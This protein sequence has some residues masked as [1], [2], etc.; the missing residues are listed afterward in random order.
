MLSD[1]RGSH[2]FT[3][4]NLRAEVAEFAILDTLLPG[5]ISCSAIMSVCLAPTC[6]FCGMAAYLGFCCPGCRAAGSHS[7]MVTHVIARSGTEGVLL[8]DLVEDFPKDPPEDLPEDLADDDTLAP[9]R[10]KTTHRGCRRRGRGRK[11]RRAADEA[12]EIADG[13]AAAVGLARDA[14]TTLQQTLAREDGEAAPAG[15]LRLQ[16]RPKAAPGRTWHVDPIRWSGPL[17]D[18]LIEV[19]L[20]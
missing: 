11:R 4:S 6:N 20:P 19:L 1:R 7:R 5:H 17:D 2:E 18:Q 13:Q 12:D 8:E 10:K 14:E 3:A 16:P 15:A 9:P